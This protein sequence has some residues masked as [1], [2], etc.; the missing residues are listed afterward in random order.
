VVTEE[1]AQ[2]IALLEAPPPG[3][4][5]CPPGRCAYVLGV[6]GVGVTVGMAANSTL[7]WHSDRVALALEELQFTVGE[8]PSVEAAAGSRVFE[9]DLA[10]GAPAR[11]PGFTSAALALG[12][13]AIFALP[14]EFGAVRLGV[15]ELHRDRPGP[16]IGHALGDALAFAQATSAVLAETPVAQSLDAGGREPVSGR[17]RVHQAAGMISVQA[18]VTVAEAL[19]RLRAYAYSHGRAVSEVA[20]D[21]VERRLKFDEAH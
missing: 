14:L 2:V 16:L 3:L 6:S 7:V 17:H 9:A 11:W 18:G 21:V 19:V 12:V 20:A 5:S 13:R 15:F 8:G 1:M 10:D 4:R